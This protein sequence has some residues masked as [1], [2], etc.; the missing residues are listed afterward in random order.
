VFGVHH[1]TLSVSDVDRSVAF[2]GTFGFRV[3]LRWE[4]PDESLSIVHLTLDGFVLEL[5]G[6]AANAGA[7]PRA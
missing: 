3:A 2:Y 1:F 7:A 6:Y 5:F 4:A